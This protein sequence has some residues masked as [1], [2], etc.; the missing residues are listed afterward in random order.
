MIFKKKM[1]LTLLRGFLVFT[2]C[3]L[4]NYL[5][6]WFNIKFEIYYIQ[7]PFYVFTIFFLSSFLLL[8]YHY[9]FNKKIKETF[10]FLYWFLCFIC[11]SSLYFAYVLSFLVNIESVVDHIIHYKYFSITIRYTDQYKFTF[12]HLYL[13]TYLNK[14]SIFI[15]NPEIIYTILQD[16]IKEVCQT[17]PNITILQIKKYTPTLIMMANLAHN[18]IEQDYLFDTQEPFISIFKG[19]RNILGTIILFKISMFLIPKTIL[20]V[21]FSTKALFIAEAILAN[22]NAVFAMSSEEY[23]DLCQA[24]AIYI[25]NNYHPLEIL[26]W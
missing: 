7:L 25:I 16:T 26:F 14:T 2:T 23:S 12:F 9:L 1:H 19:I 13:Q 4:S 5:R 15:Q 10:T 24:A 8:E 3:F 21:F 17:N 6:F 22:S 11:L 20:Y 18:S